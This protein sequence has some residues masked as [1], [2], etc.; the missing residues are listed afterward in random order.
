MTTES[1][2]A[3]KS[4]DGSQGAHAGKDEQH[5]P[6][7]HIE[8]SFGRRWREATML[9]MHAARSEDAQCGE[10]PE[11]RSS[12]KVGHELIL[13]AAR[14]SVQVVLHRA[15]E[16]E[17]RVPLFRRRQNR[18]HLAD[19]TQGHLERARNRGC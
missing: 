13:Q 3:P 11:E 5:D 9:T 10:H 6:Q 19:A 1:T 14:G 16:R 4:G 7:R 12:A 15:D 17:H 8:A 18:R 2:R